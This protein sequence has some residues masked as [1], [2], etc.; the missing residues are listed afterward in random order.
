MFATTPDPVTCRLAE[1]TQH[2]RETH[3]AY[4]HAELPAIWTLF[5]EAI[6]A[7]P[8]SATELR[9]V[10]RLF[11]QF[12]STLESHLRKEDEVLFPFIERLEHTLSAGE[13]APQHVFGPL[14][15]PIQVLEAEHTFGDRL[16]ARMRPIWQ[17][18]APLGDSFPLQTALHD[19]LQILESDMQRHVHLEDAILF[20]RTIHLEDW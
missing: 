9:G 15:I 6:A 20:P 16:L 7:S 19:R 10:G 12:R 13:P 17:R 2:I 11:G 3:H 1:L 18:W 5:R 8:T 4:L 14:A